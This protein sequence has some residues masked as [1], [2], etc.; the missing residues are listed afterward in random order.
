MR[1]EPHVRKES[2]MT[3]FLAAASRNGLAACL[4]LAGA[5]GCQFVPKSQL[6]ACQNQCRLSGEQNKA[7]QAEVANLRAHSR[8]MEDQLGQ[9]EDELT[10]IYDSTAKKGSRG[11]GAARARMVELARRYPALR[12]DPATGSCRLDAEVLF[13]PGNATLK[14]NAQAAL[15]DLAQ[16]VNSTDVK[17]LNLTVVGHAD[18]KQIAKRETRDVHPDNEHLS[19]ARARAVQHYLAQQG[20]AIHRMGVSGFGASQ[21]L[22]ANDS[23]EHR[24]LNRRVEIFLTAPEMPVIG[25]TDA[26]KRLY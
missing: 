6:A 19:T 14:S 15:K 13:D 10:G 22:A 18:D 4:L 26:T 11:H 25:R 9:A 12:Y 3:S 8:R 23:P 1:L 17:D 24:K 20:V 7:L 16:L 2:N 5:S 21:P